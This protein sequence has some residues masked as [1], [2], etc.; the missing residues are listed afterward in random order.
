KVPPDAIHDFKEIEKQRAGSLI[1]SGEPLRK[2]KFASDRRTEDIPDGYR[3][4]TVA[5]DQVAAVGNLLQAGDNVDV[6]AILH[7][8][9]AAGIPHGSTKTILQNVRVFSVNE[10]YRPSDDKSNEVIVA[11]TVSLLLPLHDAEKLELASKL[12]D[13]RL[14]LRS[15]N[16]KET[17]SSSGS[18]FGSIMGAGE[19]QSERP[20]PADK[21]SVAGGLLKFLSQQ[22]KAQTAAPPPAANADPDEHFLV[23]LMEGSELKNVELT[24][25][26]K[27][28][29][30]MSNAPPAPGAAA[31]APAANAGAP[32]AGMPLGIPGLG[33]TP[34]PSSL[35][36]TLG[37]PAAA[38]NP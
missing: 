11:K 34:D 29:R 10:Q 5:A 9:A 33:P 35:D 27:D 15:P 23:Q 26:G 18:D 6:I 25:K 19:T 3:V 31:A 30:W 13:L 12:G 37:P 28:G 7:P 22:A 4:V 17:V 24:R 1:L 21:G 16:D 36:P 20:D 32:G 14:V 8:N 38:G 2:A